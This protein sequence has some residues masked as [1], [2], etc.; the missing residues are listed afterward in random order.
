MPR[1]LVYRR[2]KEG[3]ELPDPRE[4]IEPR[5]ISRI[6]VLDPYGYGAP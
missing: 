2:F 5:R 4:A 6:Q 1:Y 3:L